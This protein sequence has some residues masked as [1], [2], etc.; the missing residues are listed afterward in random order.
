MKSDRP[1]LI[2]IFAI[3][4]VL[5]FR[6]CACNVEETEHAVIYSFG[7]PIKVIL[8]QSDNA[9]NFDDAVAGGVEVLTGAGFL[10]KAPWQSVYRVDSRLLCCDPP[11]CRIALPGGTQKELNYSCLWRV[12]D[13][14]L[15][16]TRVSNETNG[17]LAV[18]KIASSQLSAAFQARASEP[19]PAVIAGAKSAAASKLRADGIELVDVH[20]QWFDLAAGGRQA[21]DARLVESYKAK[22]AATAQ[23]AARNAE[24]IRAEADAAAGQKLALA[25]REAE[26]VRATSESESLRIINDGF[27]SSPGDGPRD[28]RPGARVR[29]ASADPEF[30]RFLQSVSA[31]EKLP[32]DRST[33]ILRKNLLDSVIEKMPGTTEED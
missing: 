18:E 12:A 6:F 24:S 31:L 5:F 28:A 19:E 30:F 25:R 3:L 15:F 17:S 10:F 27:T 8:H 4:C 9:A 22:A 33:I 14:L 13:P 26:N 32:L 29:G 23:E 1:L 2:L 16:L 7:R 21:A 11:R 20:V